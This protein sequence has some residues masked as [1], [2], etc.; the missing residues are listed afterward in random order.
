VLA[1]AKVQL[2]F[3][4]ASFFEKKFY[5]ISQAYFSVIPELV[6]LAFPLG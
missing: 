4:P 2:L 5:L 3:K 1:G 6:L